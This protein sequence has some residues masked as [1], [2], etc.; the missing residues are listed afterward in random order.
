[1][2]KLNRFE[3]AAE[4]NNDEKRSSYLL[5]LVTDDLDD[6]EM[7]EIVDTVKLSTEN[8]PKKL[9]LSKE[10][11]Q[12]YECS[13]S[14]TKE[15]LHGL[16]EIVLTNANSTLSSSANLSIGQD[17]ILHLKSHSFTDKVACDSLLAELEEISGQFKSDTFSMYDPEIDPYLGVRINKGKEKLYNWKDINLK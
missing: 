11:Q 5:R 1:M 13:T 3:I 16:L 4:L 6:R 15:V 10:W 9:L 12:G 14:R 17:L 7:M 8:H 2:S